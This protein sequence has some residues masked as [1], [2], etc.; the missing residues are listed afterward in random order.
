MRFSMDLRL[1]SDELVFMK[2]IDENCAKHISVV[3]DIFSWEKELLQSQNGHE[4]G[5]ALCTSVQVLAEEANL[6]I[7]AAKRVLFAM[8][9]EWELMHL[10]LVS[11]VAGNDD[12]DDVGKARLLRYAYGLGYQMIGNEL[13][14]AQ[15]LRY[16]DPQA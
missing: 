7:P 16:I 6:T 11:N 8:C 4:E 3:N 15:T 10:K 1:S 5:S 12:L 14:S 9:R 2:P 13:W